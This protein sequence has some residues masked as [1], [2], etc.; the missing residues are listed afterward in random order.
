[1]LYYTWPCGMF[2]EL[3]PPFYVYRYRPMPCTPAG[4]ELLKCE[5]REH[6]DAIVASMEKGMSL[7]EAIAC[8]SRE[9]K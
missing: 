6:A 8:Y 3:G 9:R 2:K 5:T 4:D 1:M 7:Q